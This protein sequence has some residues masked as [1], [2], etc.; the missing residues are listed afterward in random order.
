MTKIVPLAISQRFMWTGSKDPGPIGSDRNELLAFQVIGKITPATVTRAVNLI[1]SRH[2]PLQAS[3]VATGSGIHQVIHTAKDTSLSVADLP[4]GTDPNSLNDIRTLVQEDLFKPFDLEIAPLLRIKLFKCAPNHYLIIFISHALV[5]DGWSAEILIG[6]FLHLLRVLTGE[7][8]EPL[9]ALPVSY[10]DFALW[11]KQQVEQ[12]S[13]KAEYIE[14]WRRMAFSIETTSLQTSHRKG[15]RTIQLEPHFIFHE[16]DR[17]LSDSLKAKCL[18]FGATL[19]M[20][21]LAAYAASLRPI[22]G[23][24]ILGII[25][26]F[27]DRVLDGAGKIFGNHINP[28]C[29]KLDLRENPTITDLIDICRNSLTDAID[30]RYLPDDEEIVLAIKSSYQIAFNY[31]NYPRVDLPKSEIECIILEVNEGVFPSPF[32]LY[33]NVV[34]ERNESTTL[35]LVF[36]PQKVE[37]RTAEEILQRFLDILTSI[38]KKSDAPSPVGDA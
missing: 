32:D 16:V 35:T 29:L 12:S 24:T 13:A 30:H 9:P 28:I 34:P 4:T 15:T 10:S 21:Y 3:F 8:S 23:S 22:V 27:A 31:H 37:L 19:S 36:N 38:V 25:T 1:I 18:G 20:I 6:E 11:Q 7:I 26:A 14:W 17:N 2:E 5:Y 33:L